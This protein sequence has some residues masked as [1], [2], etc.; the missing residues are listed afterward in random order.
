MLPAL[1]PQG[2]NTPGVSIAIRTGTMRVTH[3]MNVPLPM[4]LF[5]NT[6]SGRTPTGRHGV[7]DACSAKTDSFSS[8]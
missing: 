5:V 7:P 3:A 1:D 6:A 8:A 4:S 2:S